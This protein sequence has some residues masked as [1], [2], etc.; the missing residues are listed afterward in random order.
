MTAHDPELQAA[1]A[2]IQAVIETDLSTYLA[3]DRTAW[4]KNWVQDERFQSIMECGTMQIARGYAEFRRNVFDSMD[5]SPGPIHADIRRENITIE[6]HGD[7]AWATFDEIATETEN[8]LIAPNLSHNFRLF[9]RSG[10]RWRILFHG[11]WA[12]PLRDISSP[13]VEVNQDCGVVWLNSAASE[14]LRTFEGLTISHGTLRATSPSWDKGL[15]ET[16]SR[17]HKLKGFGQFS[18]VASAGENSVTFPVVLG[19]DGEGAL[20]TCWVRVADCRVYVLFG[21]N[22]DLSKQIRIAELIFGLSQ[23]QTEILDRIARGFDL[24]GISA[25]LGFSRNTARTHLRRIFEKV[26]V[27]S[28][29]ELLRT[30][31][32]FRV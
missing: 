9:E 6:V 2:E 4:E 29:I 1:R 28:Q 21:E 17:S 23:T 22:P 5:A 8:P 12:E 31:I 14:C 15:R 26:G 11:C 30:L 10:R 20:L 3:R 24:S 27:R 16:V 19:E 25:E 18:Q 32:S 7:M 13:A